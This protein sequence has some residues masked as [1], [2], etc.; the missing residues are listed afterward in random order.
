M[1]N[2]IYTI[3]ASLVPLM[4]LS[5]AAC[6]KTVPPENQTSEVA[7]ADPSTTEE[8]RAPASFDEPPPVGTRA[9]CPVMEMNFTVSE[10]AP[11]S[12]YKDKHYVFCCPP[13]KVKFDQDP[14]KY[15]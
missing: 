1:K 2:S 7:A 4:A 15:I 8:E 5:L 10:G 11:Y 3:S 14:E 9:Y 6:A 12:V 13:C